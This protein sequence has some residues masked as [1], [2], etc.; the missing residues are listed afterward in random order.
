MR[1]LQVLLNLAVAGFLS[2]QWLPGA[3]TSFTE[4]DLLS[5]RATAPG[6]KDK[7]ALGEREAALF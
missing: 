7:E 5:L 1:A 2:P 6:D 3:M 4:W